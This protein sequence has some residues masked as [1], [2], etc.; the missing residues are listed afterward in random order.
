M[1]ELVDAVTRDQALPFDEA[2]AAGWI[3][4]IPADQH[5]AYLDLN[6]G[7]SLAP[8]ARRARDRVHAAARHRPQ[9]GGAVLA[10][11]GFRRRA[12]ARAGRSPTASSP[13]FTFRA[14]NPEVRESM[15]RAMRAGRCAR[16]R[17][18]CW[19][20]DP[21]AD[22][23]GLV[24]ACARRAATASSSATRSPRCSPHFKLEKL[25]ALGR[26]P[27]RPLL[28]KT[29]VTTEL[30]AAIARNFGAALVGDLLVG[31]KYHRPTCSSGSSAGDYPGVLATLDDFVV[32]VE[33]SHGMLVTPEMRDKDA[34]GAALLLAELA[35][36]LIEQGRT[37][38]DYL[39]GIYLELGYFAN[40]LTST[41]M[42]GAMGLANIRRIQAALRATPPTALA[43]LRVVE[44]I[45]HLDESGPLGPIV[46]ATDAASRDVLVFR[47]E[48]GARAILRPSGTEPKNKAYVEVPLSPLGV[49]AGAAALARQR[50]EGDRRALEIADSLSQQ[51]LRVIGVDLPRFA[52]RVSGLVS[53]DHRI[54]FAHRFVPAL[55]E[56][57]RANPPTAELRAWI[58]AGLESYG[59]D[60][61]GL[62]ADAMR[63]FLG[64]ERAAGRTPGPALDAI[65]RAF[66]LDVT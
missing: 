63:A 55:V 28:I 62:T 40:R 52:L 60:A 6:V 27:R 43:G 48:G 65:E 1:A 25:A 56:R 57:A 61:R 58:D 31:F 3:A 22:R 45:D 10:A 46:S 36:E 17:R 38:V 47:L 16:R 49:D 50:A 39:D 7:Q 5:K 64:E 18:S 19:P 54:D 2:R 9:H 33:E 13:T 34:A 24:R 26:L 12:S 32:G 51:M 37:L 11:A 44:A 59:K 15:E 14:P 29:E 30:I 23:I 41:V 4:P 21:D 20:R 66:F 8:R 42:T 35:S 53:L